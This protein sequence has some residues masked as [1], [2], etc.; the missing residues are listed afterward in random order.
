M[1]CRHL[2]MHPARH[3]LPEGISWI[4]IRCVSYITWCYTY[5]RIWYTLHDRADHR[6]PAL[7]L[8]LISELNRNPHVSCLLWCHI[9]TFG[10]ANTRYIC[11]LQDL[12]LRL[13]L[14]RHHPLLWLSLPLS[15]DLN[16]SQAL[17]TKI[18]FSLL[19]LSFFFS[20]SIF[21]FSE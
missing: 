7:S 4:I 14:R 20:F 16:W 6:A 11:S 3:Q 13:V 8:N 1:H 9:R 21:S 18:I 10:G 19:D 15:A 12:L 2:K 5:W 17:L